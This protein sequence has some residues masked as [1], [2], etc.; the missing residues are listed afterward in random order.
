[1]TVKLSPDD[2]TYGMDMPEELM[3]LLD[4]DPEGNEY[5]HQL[6]PVNNE[7]S[8]TIVS[9]VKSPESRLN[10]ALAIV[11]HLKERNGKLDFKLLNEVIKDYNQRGKLN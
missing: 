10:K 1:M 5:F 4:Q 2:S 11:H 6:T 8:S 3:I 9:K 7:T